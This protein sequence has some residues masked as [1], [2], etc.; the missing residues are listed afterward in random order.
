VTAIERNGLHLLVQG[1]FTRDWESYMFTSY[2]NKETAQGMD[3]FF[4]RATPG[5]NTELLSRVPTWAL[6]SLDSKAPQLPPTGQV[7]R[8]GF[9]Y[10]AAIGWPLPCLKCTETHPTGA[11]AAQLFGC[12]SFGGRIA[13]PFIPVWSGLLLNSVA[14]SPVQFLLYWTWRAWV[15]RFRRTSGQCPSCGY[16][17]RGIAPESVCP[18]CAAKPA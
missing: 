9:L 3:A 12:L 8:S 18:E 17:R 10:V 15:R 4:R 16:D 5:E 11:A 1:S 6:S 7:Q 14:F 2:G 13:L